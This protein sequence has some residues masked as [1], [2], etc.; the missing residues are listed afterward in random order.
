MRTA[1]FQQSVLRWEPKAVRI[2]NDDDAVELGCVTYG[3]M[4]EDVGMHDEFGLV[5]L[6]VDENDTFVFNCFNIFFDC[7]L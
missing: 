4:D 6:T 5:R 7:P 3:S 2:R 1:S